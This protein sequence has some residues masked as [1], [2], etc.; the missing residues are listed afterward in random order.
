MRAFP[1]YKNFPRA[2]SEQLTRL[3]VRSNFMLNGWT[4]DELKDNAG[5]FDDYG[6][7]ACDVMVVN[8]GNLRII[9]TR[10]YRNKS[11]SLVYGIL[12]TDQKLIPDYYGCGRLVGKQ[13]NVQE[14]FRMVIDEFGGTRGLRAGERY[15][16]PLTISS[17]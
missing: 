8:R 12:T 14:A 17:F 9:F 11:L 1:E 16:T 4:R 6:V 7:G 15:F 10:E 2:F 3:K 13:K 5:F